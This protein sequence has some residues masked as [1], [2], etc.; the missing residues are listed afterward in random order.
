M[1][2]E[3]LVGLAANPWGVVAPV[4]MIALLTIGINFVT[5]GIQ[6]SVVGIVRESDAAG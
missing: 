3:N 4:V 6:R 2:Y 1:I 5:D